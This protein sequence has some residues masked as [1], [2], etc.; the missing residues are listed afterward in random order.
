MTRLF[1]EDDWKAIRSGCCDAATGDASA[2]APPLSRN[3]PATRSTASRFS[4]L[5]SSASTTLRPE[6]STGETGE[7]GE[8]GGSG[9]AG[10]YVRAGETA[11]CGSNRVDDQ[12]D[13]EAALLDQGEVDA[14]F[15]GDGAASVASAPGT[16][17]LAANTGRFDGLVG[18][19]GAD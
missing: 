1:R 6:W 14:G 4:S 11:A 10:E 13:G 8:T 5:T 3:Q 7:T 16:G 19:A 15:F 9:E 17:F 18:D 12:G 2:S